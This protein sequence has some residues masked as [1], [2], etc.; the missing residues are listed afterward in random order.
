MRQEVDFAKM[1]SD[2]AMS[3]LTENTQKEK[4]QAIERPVGF[5][6]HVIYAGA[7]YDEMVKWY[8]TLLGGTVTS[9][10]EIPADLLARD[11]CD[12]V[13]IAKR[14]DLAQEEGPVRTGV[15]HVAWSYAS[16]AELMQMYRHG[17]KNGIEPQSTLNTGI[18]LQIYYTDPEGNGVEFQ[19]D[20]HDTSEATQA[21]Q[22][23]G[24]RSGNA[25][26]W[27]YNP[28]KIIALMEAGWSDYDIL[29]HEKFHAADVPHS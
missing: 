6:H 16:I 9:G 10:E 15:F 8:G 20:A 21:A 7:K 11:D 24:Q 12:T 14:T 22:R 4:D 26:H 18:L 3:E 17:L 2:P 19:V 1:E 5:G 27:L 25:R 29:D 23:N 28:E 13:V